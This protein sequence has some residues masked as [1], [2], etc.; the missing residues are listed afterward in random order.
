MQVTVALD[1]RY[2][3]TPDGVAWTQYGMGQAFWERYLEVFDSVKIVARATPVERP[4]EGWQQVTGPQISLHAVPDVNGPWEALKQF[5]PFRKSIRSA[6]PEHGAVILR[7]A[8]VVGNMLEG[9]LHRRNYPYALEVVGD[10]YEVFAPGVFRHPLRPFFRWYFYRSLRRQCSGAIGVA[11]V[12][13]QSLQRRYPARSLSVS[14][15]DVELVGRARHGAV[16]STSYSSIELASSTIATS[17]R[18]P[19]MTGRRRLITVGSLAQLYKGTDI[20]ISALDLCVRQGLDLEADILGD[21][22]YRAA[23]MEQAERAGLGSRVRFHGHVPAGEPVM[24]LLDEA[25]LFVLPSRTEG[26][27]RAMIEAMARGV[28]CIGSDVGG[29][30]ELLDP[31]DLVTPGDAV[32]LAARIQE[33]LANP[34]RMEAMSRRNLELASQYQADTLAKR[35]RS[36]YRHIRD[37][38]AAREAALTGNRRS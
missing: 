14:I 25:D 17:A 21:G 12:T 19:R 1:L 3:V 22:K 24:K 7:A 38:I 5:F 11:Y 13:R 32:V 30:P 27:P 16:F 6:M 33:V 10:P 8:S 15:S 26:L 35:R 4:P 18:G 9:A 37:A 2:A 31:E 23:L 34:T 28:P 20:L 36:F 29:I